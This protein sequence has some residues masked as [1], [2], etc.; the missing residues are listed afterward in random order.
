MMGK[1]QA[2]GEGQEK[3]HVQLQSLLNTPNS[4]TEELWKFYQG[5]DHTEKVNLHR[6]MSKGTHRTWICVPVP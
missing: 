6:C 5:L 4:K 2:V 3:V 1:S